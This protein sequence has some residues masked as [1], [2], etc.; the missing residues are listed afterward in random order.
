MVALPPVA[1]LAGGLATRLLPITERTPKSLVSV[2][3]RP[4]IAH[5]LEL[6][7]ARGVREI[8]MCVGFLSDQII[9]Y[10]GD[11][12]RF[13]MTVQYSSESPRLLGTGGAIKRALPLLGSQFFVL[14][15]DSY[16]QCNYESVFKSFCDSE[17]WAM[18]TVFR[19]E[20]LWDASNVDFYDGRVRAYSKRQRTTNMRHIDFGLGVFSQEAFEEF[21]ADTAFDLAT[22]YE[23]L[24]KKDQ[25][26]GFEVGERFYEIGSRDGLDEL[27]TFLAQ[28]DSV[29]H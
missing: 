18:M 24:L 6:L 26:A 15:G 5:Q 25:L 3:G 22:V 9:D 13:G 27:S 29:G 12:N 11:G 28:Q 20:G 19:N 2:N 7:R 21:P 23:G 4:F 10:V 16:L 8:V 1:I 14:Y 17:R